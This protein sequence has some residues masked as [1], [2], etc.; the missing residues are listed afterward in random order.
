MMLF[1]HYT[2]PFSCGI[3]DVEKFMLNSKL[4]TKHVK[5]YVVELSIMTLLLTST[6][7]FS[8]YNLCRDSLKQPK[9]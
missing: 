6:S 9:A 2:S 3:L 1:L 4:F 7:T 8:L 5:Q